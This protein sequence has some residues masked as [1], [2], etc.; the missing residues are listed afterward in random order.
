MEP[1]Q[2]V[3]EE[4]LRKLGEKMDVY[5]KILSKQKYL[6]GDVRTHRI[7][8]PYTTIST[9][10][11]FLQEVTLADLFHLSY[12]YELD[13]AGFEWQSSRPNVAR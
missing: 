13:K 5:D 6:G 11:F 3:L 4:H 7:S 1:D 9:F 12:G 10:T 8:Y 2:A